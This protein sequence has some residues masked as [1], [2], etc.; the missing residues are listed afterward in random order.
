MAENTINETPTVENDIKS[1]SRKKST[2]IDA[3]GFP[4]SLAEPSDLKDEKPDI[5]VDPEEKEASS[6]LG[7]ETD[8]PSQAN[9]NRSLFRNVNAIF[10]HQ[11]TGNFKGES[12]NEISP[13]ISVTAP[14][15]DEKSDHNVERERDEESNHLCPLDDHVLKHRTETC[16]SKEVSSSHYLE[17]G[18]NKLPKRKHSLESQNSDTHNPLQMNQFAALNLESSNEV[19]SGDVLATELI[20]MFETNDPEGVSLI[21]KDKESIRSKNISNVYSDSNLICSTVQSEMTGSAESCFRRTDPILHESEEHEYSDSFPVRE[22]WPRSDALLLDGEN[23]KEST[24]VNIQELDEKE[25]QLMICHSK[26]TNEVS[27]SSTETGNNYEK[28]NETLSAS[29]TS[30]HEVLSHTITCLDNDCTVPS[31]F[32]A[33]QFFLHM[34]SCPRQSKGGCTICFAMDAM[35]VKHAKICQVGLYDNCPIPN[36]DKVKVKVLGHWS[37]LKAK[38][39]VLMQRAFSVLSHARICTSEV[40]S[41]GE[42]C[43]KLKL[44]LQHMQSC[45]NEL[46]C[47]TKKCFNSLCFYHRST[48]VDP[49]CPVDFCRAEWQRKLACVAHQMAVQ[50]AYLIK[51]LGSDMVAV[52]AFPSVPIVN[53]EVGA[54]CTLNAELDTAGTVPEKVC[55]CDCVAFCAYN[56]PRKNKTRAKSATGSCILL[57]KNTSKSCILRNKN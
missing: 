17:L 30:F 48:C 40:C 36:C 11:Y 18:N 37:N 45:E 31:C 21:E 47:G 56:L 5:H 32:T 35:V 53:Q 41:V 44:H 38:H 50:P 7:G 13:K 29:D 14:V 28:T 12:A 16:F 8:K 4:M 3:N 19:E 1:E 27:D 49:N 39:A 2:K 54:S 6:C 51:P 43:Q 23:D 57:S 33:K 15:A 25:T 52:K 26:E 42:C 10:D 55:T 22:T 20:K 24:N 46:D 9:F 34:S